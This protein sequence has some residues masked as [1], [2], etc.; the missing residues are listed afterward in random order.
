MRRAAHELNL[1][2]TVFVLPGGGG[3]YDQR[4]SE[5]SPRRWRYRLPGTP[6]WEPRSSSASGWAWTP[7][8]PQDGR[9][10]R[11]GGALARRR[12]RRLREMAQPVP[13]W[14]AFDGAATLLAAVGVDRSELPVEVYDNGPRHT[15]VHLADAASRWRR[16]RG[17]SAR[18]KGTSELI[19]VSCFAVAG[20]QVKTRMFGPNWAS[21]RIPPRARRPDRWR[22]I[23]PATA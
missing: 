11:I 7:Y 19:G 10:R 9:G 2:E 5:S 15:Y 23:S 20:A 17:Y 13:T 8:C 21:P 18:F 6:S 3:R 16:W 4:T 14:T 1:S 22:S 12:A